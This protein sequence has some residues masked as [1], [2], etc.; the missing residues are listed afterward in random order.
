MTDRELSRA[1][2]HLADECGRISHR[3]FASH[4]K[5]S[6][7]FSFLEDEIGRYSKN[8]KEGKHSNAKLLSNFNN[9]MLQF[10]LRQR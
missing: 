3:F 5:T 9:E 6:K 8:I 4:P 7:I 2:G 10:F 1:L